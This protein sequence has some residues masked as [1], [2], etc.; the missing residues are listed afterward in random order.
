MSEHQQALRYRP[1]IDGLRAVAVVAVVLF[2]ANVPNLDGGFVGV[3]V[4]FV[5]SGFLITK[6]LIADPSIVSFY[7][8]RARRILPALFF[9]LAIVL[10]AG[11]FIL[12]PQDYTAMAKSAGTSVAFSS[13]IWFWRQSDYF[14]RGTE[15][16]PLLHTWS[17]GVEE[18]FYIAFPLLVRMFGRLS[19]SRLALIFAVCAAASFAVAVYAVDQGKGT[20]AFYQSP[21]RAW[22]LL[23]GSILA[24]GVIPPLRHAIGRSLL[25]GAGIAAILVSIVAIHALPPFPG[26]GAL[27]PVLGAAALI[28]AGTGGKTWLT[29]VLAAKPVV[30]IG[31]ISYSLYLWHWPFLALARYVAIEPLSPWQIIAALA[32]ALGMAWVSWRFVERPFRRPAIA[33]RTIWIGSLGGMAALG[34]AAVAITVGDGFPARFS[35]TLV[36]LNAGSGATWRCPIADFVPLG[37][38]YGCQI[39]LPKRDPRTAD[40]VLWGDSHAQMYAPAVRAA[41]GT[42]RVLLVNAYGC[43]PVV[44]DAINP[45][46][47][48]V[49]RTNYA[50]IVKLPASTVIIAQNWPQYRD[51]ATARL[52]RTP[53]PEER[54]QD[55]IRRLRALVAGLRANGKRVVIVTP[56]AV[57]G[58][59]VASVASRELLFRKRITSAV[60]ISRGRYESE[61]ANVLAAM[62]DLARDGG[63][64]IVRIDQR[65]C[66]PTY[67][68]FLEDNQA[69]FADYGHFS[70]KAVIRF[71]P[72]FRDAIAA[73]TGES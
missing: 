29:P 17:L 66:S 51:E 6:G 43:A 3:D 19:K 45:V 26:L 1:D 58:Y 57:P 20:L 21:M 35:P 68:A 42:H 67:C 7:Q 53:L 33:N 44:G 12:L 54:Y 39:T 50:A 13:N 18:Q 4:F 10:V 38:Y 36:A 2:H 25:A 63:V 27:P 37:G 49:Q 24:T 73:A 16:W 52:G 34:A 23:M 47:G 61:Y 65:A 72:L 41:A 71:A 32:F 9:M 62:R 22:E 8:R 64:H 55:G 15:L 69:I 30:A 11:L 48:N 60:G 59:N 31:L 46:C 5:I 28:H 14:A 70:T 40:I 56:I